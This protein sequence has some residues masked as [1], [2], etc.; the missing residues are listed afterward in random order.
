VLER[1]GVWSAVSRTAVR[2]ENIAQTL[3]FVESGAVDVGLVALTDVLDKGADRYWT[4]PTSLHDPIRQDAVLLVR[5][6]ENA[7]A[8]AFLEHLKSTSARALI[9]RSGYGI[10][11]Q[12]VR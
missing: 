3:Q 7:S 1:L 10:A 4:V 8:S 6:E 12:S 2:G 9:E 11:P 5:G